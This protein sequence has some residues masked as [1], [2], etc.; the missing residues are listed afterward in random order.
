VSHTDED[1]PRERRE[2]HIY[3]D[4]VEEDNRLPNWWL[5][6][7]FGTIV[8]AFGYWAYYQAFTGPSLLSVFQAEQRA[9]RQ[10]EMDRVMAAGELT[11]AALETMAE[12]PA[13]VA[14]GKKTYEAMCAACHRADGG[15]TVGPNLT[16]K[17]WLHGGGPLDI[18]RTVRDGVP[19]KGM[20][21][22]GPQLGEVKVRAVVAYILTL[23]DKNVDGGKPPQGQPYPSSAAAGP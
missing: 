12:T 15:G 16:D 21:A 2:V 8:F 9:A 6:T 5:Y 3:D 19:D 23:R 20:M 11:P 13:V 17:H 14:E 22:W 1:P 7:L 4:I 10:A 18:A